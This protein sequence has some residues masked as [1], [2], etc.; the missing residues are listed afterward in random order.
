MTDKK[1][2]YLLVGVGSNV[3][4]MHKAGLE[5]DCNEV[6]AVCDI[7]EEPARR[8]AEAWNCPY[9]LDYKQMIAENEAD[10][11]I[12]MVPHT[13]HA[14]MSIYA[15]QHGLNVLC[16]KPM[17][18]HV[19]EADQMIAV[20][21][22]TGKV[23]AINFQQRL[24]PEVVAAKELIDEGR[25]GKIQQVD[26]KITWTRTYKYYREAGWRGSWAG[27]G[28]ALLMN[29]GPHDL[30]MICHLAGMPKRVY[31]WTPTI[32]HQITP[33][34][35]A[36]AMME[37]DNGALGSLH[38]STAE[39]GQPQ[40]FEI[41]GT[42]GHLQINKGSLRFA[43][44]DTDVIEFIKASD[45]SFAEPDMI[46]ESIPMD[47]QYTGSHRDTH[48][49]FYHA[50]T[51]HK[52]ASADGITGIRGLELANAMIY[53]NYTGQAVDFPLDREKYAALLADL[54]AREAAQQ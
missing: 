38:A 34:D 44:F 47:P 31:A 17:A 15:M 8:E 16:E 18:I 53:S 10:A 2:R 1:L 11:L 5:L 27:E 25:L 33:E 37:W 28:G 24:R 50:V 32:A 36:Q 39:A 20:A 4:N 49:D 43:S 29:Q 21:K 26:V 19:A 52:P 6:V 42:Q 3:Y 54:R 48:L 22:E 12:V 30:D 41:I 14:E 9:Y 13:L 46:E 23:L 45:K 7:R 35:T 51:Q 40:R